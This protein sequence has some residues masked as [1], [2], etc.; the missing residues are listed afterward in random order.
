MSTPERITMAVTVVGVLVAMGSLTFDWRGDQR[1]SATVTA[2]GEPAA[3]APSG[4]PPP[5]TP[6][7]TAPA[8]SALPTEP[9]PATLAD[10]PPPTRKP[11]RPARESRR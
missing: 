1:D 10:D 7:T 6:P 3:E 2:T 9:A 4:A 11:L 8:P 5:S